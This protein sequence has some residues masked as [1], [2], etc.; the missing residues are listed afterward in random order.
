MAQHHDHHRGDDRHGG[1]V[2]HD[3]VLDHRGGDAVAQPVPGDVHVPGFPWGVGLR[4]H[5]LCPGARPITTPVSQ[6][7]RETQRLSSVSPPG[8]QQS[9]PP[10]LRRRVGGVRRP[11]DPGDRGSQL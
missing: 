4:R 3:L 7:I 9:P 5:P 10:T 6:A 2:L 8:P 1:A 11:D